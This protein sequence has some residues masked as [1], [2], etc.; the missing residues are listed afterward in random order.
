MPAIKLIIYFLAA[1]LIGSFAVHNMTSVEVRYYDFQLDLKTLE[2]PLVTAVLIPLGIG[3]LGAWFMW[4][5][6]SI[7][8]QLVI[9]KQN[10]TISLMEEELVML[11]AVGMALKLI[12]KK[13]KAY[14]LMF[15]K[16]ESNENSLN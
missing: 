13:A 9:R 5:S 11:G 16:G 10:K 3:L 15:E 6:N 12:A 7:K 2:L 4:L 1:V 8:M 14:E